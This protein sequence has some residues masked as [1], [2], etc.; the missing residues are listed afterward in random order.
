M[1]LENCGLDIPDSQ[2]SIQVEIFNNKQGSGFN[3][4]THATQTDL[5]IYYNN[6]S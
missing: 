6:R 1:F 5:R 3:F 4:H 2:I